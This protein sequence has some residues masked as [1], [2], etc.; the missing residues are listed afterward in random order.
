VSI[1]QLGRD[2]KYVP[3]PRSRF[4]PVRAEDVTRWVFNE[5]TTSL[6]TW[7]RLLRGWVRAEL[8]PLVNS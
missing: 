3:V 5:D 4:L 2:G 8:E 7:E 6:V 1:E